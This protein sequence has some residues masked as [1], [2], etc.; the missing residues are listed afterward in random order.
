MHA[1]AEEF[2]G[3]SLPAVIGVCEEL[4]DECF[5]GAFVPGG[6]VGDDDGRSEVSVRA[7]CH[8][9][10]FGDGSAVDA[11][12]EGTDPVRVSAGGVRGGVGIGVL[13]HLGEFPK[14]PGFYAP[15]RAE[16][17]FVFRR[18]G[19]CSQRD[20][21]IHNSPA[22][23]G[24]RIILTT[25]SVIPVVRGSHRASRLCRVIVI[26]AVRVHRRTPDGC[27]RVL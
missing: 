27:K 2:F 3:E 7:G 16:T 11:V 9:R 10:C 21:R 4:R 5:R 8:K 22:F 23:P 12:E 20:Q 26:E 24:S 25:V 1:M 15:G 14:I 17:C 18:P 13:I 19:E 6:A